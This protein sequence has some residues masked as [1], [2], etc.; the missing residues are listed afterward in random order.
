MG[1]DV[2]LQSSCT[3]S[4]RVASA[5]RFGSRETHTSKPRSPCH[6]GAVNPD[7]DLYEPLLST[8][9]GIAADESPPDWRGVFQPTFHE[10][11]SITIR[12][13]DLIVAQLR[14]GVRAQIMALIGVRGVTGRVDGDDRVEAR[15]TI[16]DALFGKFEHTMK[17]I[18]PA[19]LDSSMHA[20]R[21]G[22]VLVGQVGRHRFRASSPTR[23]A[24]PRH[25]AFFVALLQLAAGVLPDRPLLDELGRYLD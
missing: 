16:P 22:I 4:G 3:G 8:A 9:L 12:G 13:R 23:A 21:D 15:A 5:Q 2:A 17:Q 14:P 20:A 24:A 7:W 1:N 11:A 19:T 18:D 25:H 10:D 6:A